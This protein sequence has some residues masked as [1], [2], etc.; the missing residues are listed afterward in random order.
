MT[1]LLAYFGWQGGTIHQLA[2]DTGVPSETLLYG[3]PNRKN[4]AYDLGIF[5]MR[6]TTV[7][8]RV[9]CAKH[10]KG[11]VDYWLGVAEA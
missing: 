5:S 8:F 4:R 6:R 1:N 3:E 9:E 11:N 2:K 10:W 7:H